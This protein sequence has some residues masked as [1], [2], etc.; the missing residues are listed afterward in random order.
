MEK[1]LSVKAAAE[2]AGVS[3]KLVYPWVEERRLAHCRPGGRGKRG[4]ILIDP[5]DLESFM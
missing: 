5:R 4:R 1:L 3:V 2:R